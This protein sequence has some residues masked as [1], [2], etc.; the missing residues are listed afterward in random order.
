MINSDRRCTLLL[1]PL[2]H[3]RPVQPTQTWSSHHSD[4]P[5]CECG[6]TIWNE[7][8]QLSMVK[9]NFQGHSVR[10][11]AI[12]LGLLLIGTIFCIRQPFLLVIFTLKHSVKSSY[13]KQTQM[14]NTWY[15]WLF[16]VKMIP[17][18]Y[19]M[20]LLCMFKLFNIKNFKGNKIH[21]LPPF[22]LSFMHYFPTFK[23]YFYF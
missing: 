21:L 4:Q 5:Q 11:N 17:A 9:G 14:L 8:I 12:Y 15:F 1:S 22:S 19:T 10:D 18:E 7:Q 13:K 20:K 23:S 2:K 16:E 3:S 6:I